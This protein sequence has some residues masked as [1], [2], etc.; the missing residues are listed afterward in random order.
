MIPA[1]SF[2]FANTGIVVDGPSESNL[3]VRAYRMLQQD[4]DLPPVAMHLH[5]I[6]PMGAG[7]GGGSSD[8]AHTLMLL[9]L[10]FDMG[11]S[12]G[13]MR[14]Y[15]SRLGSDC[16]FFIEQQAMIG[17]GKGDLLEEANVSLKGKFLVII[18]PAISVS[19]AEAY[20]QVVPGSGHTE[21]RQIVEG[22]RLENWRY[23]LANDFEVGIFERYPV[24]REL[25]TMLYTQGAVYAAMSGSGSS[26]FGIFDDFVDLSKSAGDCTYW[27]ARL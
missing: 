20:R 23:T 5:K 19:T 15:A 10:I 6:V 21:L 27:A 1:T 8:A 24:L 9:N 22:E 14:H 12:A 18:K 2:S 26:V 17:T 25:K 13:H 3:C 4:Y 11:L 7:L 16:A